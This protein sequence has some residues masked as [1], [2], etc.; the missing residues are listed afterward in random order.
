MATVTTQ[1]NPVQID[2][3]PPSNDFHGVVSPNIA[4]APIPR[5][6]VAAAKSGVVAVGTMDT[7]PTEAEVLALLQT[8]EFASADNVRT[9]E[10]DFVA[11]KP[12]SCAALCVLARIN[13]N[14]V[15]EDS[16]A[17]ALGYD[18]VIMVKPNKTMRIRSS[19]AITKLSVVAVPSG[20]T[21]ANYE[22]AELYM[23][24]V[25]YV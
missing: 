16:L 14:D 20:V 17:F 6:T 18:D 25:R 4:M 13:G 8:V 2:S 24:G 21:S 5:L 1:P 22:G 15:A 3:L 19:V 23:K 9:V 10:L 11:A 12:D 7:T